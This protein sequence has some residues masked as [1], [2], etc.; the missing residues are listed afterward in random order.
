[1]TTESESQANA[2]MTE[3][4]SSTVATTESDAATTNQLL[5]DDRIR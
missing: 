2:A 3:S 4:D 5:H 1:M